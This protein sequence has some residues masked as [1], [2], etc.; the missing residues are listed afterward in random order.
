MS[1]DD[2]QPGEFGPHH[3]AVVEVLRVALSEN[4]LATQRT[5]PDD[6]HLIRFLNERARLPPP[7]CDRIGA[8]PLIW[9]D[10]L[11]LLRSEYISPP[12]RILSDDL[13]GRI[14]D[15]VSAVGCAVEDSLL[16]RLP[17]LPRDMR[18]LVTAL[19]VDCALCRAERGRTSEFWEHVFGCLHAGAIPVSWTG[20]WPHGKLVAY[21][22]AA[23]SRATGP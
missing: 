7:R 22:P 5:P 21:F 18:R 1:H 14:V 11:E 2:F 12:S 16:E 13:T 4:F 17:S 19:A 20:R 8:G 10:L 15:R 9:D 6:V 23:A 3:D